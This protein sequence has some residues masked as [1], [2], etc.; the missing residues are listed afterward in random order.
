[1]AEKKYK[2]LIVD[3]DEFLLNLYVSKFTKEGLDAETAAGGA[4]ALEKL[5]SGYIPDAMMLDMVM[6]GMGGLDLLTEIKKQKLG[7]GS[8]IIILT[9][10]GAPEDIAQATKLGADGFIVK[11][12]SIPS[13]V[14]TELLKILKERK[15]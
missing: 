2:I 5:K 15:K 14:L 7:V 9:N 11:A 13:E 1:M 10:Q 4:A 12:T 3:D 8:I 6:P